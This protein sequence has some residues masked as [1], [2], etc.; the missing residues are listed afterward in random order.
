MIC[1]LVTGNKTAMDKQKLFTINRDCSLSIELK[2]IIDGG[3][4]IDSVIKDDVGHYIVVCHVGQRVIDLG[5]LA[6][7]YQEFNE[8]E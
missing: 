2:I 6:K 3:Y 5:A 7:L 1:A 8:N 4:V